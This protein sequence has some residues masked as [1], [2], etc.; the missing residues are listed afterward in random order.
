[1]TTIQIC[2]ECGCEKVM[3][4]DGYPVN[5]TEDV[6]D[7]DTFASVGHVEVTVRWS[8]GCS[9][10][11]ME[12]EKSPQK[13]NVPDTWIPEEL[14]EDSECPGCGNKTLTERGIT[15][16]HNDGSKSG[17]VWLSCI[18]CEWDERGDGGEE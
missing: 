2:P 8:C 11:D 14:D 17:S 12:A 10:I 16:T 13:I 1:M 15:A 5:T 3:D 7:Y 9:Y 4:A 18:N 6:E